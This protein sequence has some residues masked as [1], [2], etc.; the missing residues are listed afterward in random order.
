LTRWA[1]IGLP[2][3]LYPVVHVQRK[4]Q[5]FDPHR[6]FLRPLPETSATTAFKTQTCWSLMAT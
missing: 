1:L 6:W 4:W 2:A 3:Q 5:T